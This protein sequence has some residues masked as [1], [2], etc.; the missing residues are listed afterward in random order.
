[1]R[2]L[3]CSACFCLMIR[4]PPRS[5]LFPY[6]TLFRSSLLA[7]DDS[8]VEFEDD[9]LDA[10]ADRVRLVPYEIELAP[11]DIAH[12]RAP[13]KASLLDDPPQRRRRDRCDRPAGRMDPARE[14]ILVEV[15]PHYR[16]VVGDRTM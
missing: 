11:L 6:T 4:R 15:E 2:L 12:Q 5:P 13:V 16:R 1:P 8:L 10:V 9:C 14:G 7:T 3:L